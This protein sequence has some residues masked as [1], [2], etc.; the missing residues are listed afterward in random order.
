MRS[1]EVMLAINPQLENE[2]LD[3]LLDKVKKLI[4][5]AKGEITK[6]NKWGKRKLA[7]EIKNFT[8]AI[9]VVLNFDVDEKIVAEFERVLKLEKKVI[10]KLLTLKPKKKSKKIAN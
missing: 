7:Y 5:Q 6:T 10:R 9:Y 4:T 3:P 2:E 8:E 1:Y